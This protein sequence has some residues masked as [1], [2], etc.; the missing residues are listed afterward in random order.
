MVNSGKN[1]ETLSADELVNASRLLKRRKRHIEAPAAFRV[2]CRTNQVQRPRHPAI[3]SRD[4]RG[5][6][7]VERTT[8]QIYIRDVRVLALVERTSFEI[9]IGNWRDAM[10][11]GRYSRMTLFTMDAIY[12]EKTSEH[13]LSPGDPELPQK[14]TH[15]Y[16]TFETSAFS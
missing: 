1:L 6:A 13:R 4:V 3:H 7:L 5:L 12:Q 15:F 8:P 10:H 16:H 14:N 11:D 2:E 9:R